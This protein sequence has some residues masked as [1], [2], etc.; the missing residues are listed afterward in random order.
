MSSSRSLNYHLDNA[1]IQGR[2]F[3]GF[4]PN[5]DFFT[6]TPLKLYFLISSLEHLSHDFLIDSDVQKG[7]H[8]ISDF[9][10][11]PDHDLAS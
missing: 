6:S 5:S 8:M 3:S 2:K 9:F 4:S 11:E 7:F 10:I 1:F